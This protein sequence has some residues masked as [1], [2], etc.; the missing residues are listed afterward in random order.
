MAKNTRVVYSTDTGRIRS[1]RASESP[2]ESDG[3]VRIRRES[4]GRGGKAVSVITGLGLD[5][6]ELKK[7]AKTLKQKCG[8]GGA[9]KQW[10]IEIQGDRRDQ[11]KLLLE[12][13]GYK[14]KLAGG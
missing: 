5:G 14:V 4:K 12:D 8:V 6:A 7:L 2:P 10:D 3:V 9:V 11:L 13:R 1:E